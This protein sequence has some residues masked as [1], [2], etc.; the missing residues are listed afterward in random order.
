[1]RQMSESAAAGLSVLEGLIRRTSV[2]ISEMSPL[3]GRRAYAFQFTRNS[4]SHM[5]V[6]SD[7]FLSDLPA[8]REYQESTK[9]YVEGL[10]GRM[11]NAS[12]SDFYCVSGIPLNIEIE[13]PTEPVP[14]YTASSVQVRVQDLRTQD[15]MAI[16]AVRI[17]HQQ[18]F[19]SLQKDPFLKE[20]AVVNSIRAAADRNQLSYFRLNEHPR[21]LPWVDL[22]VDF[23]RAANEDEIEQ[24][25]L[26]KIYWLGFKRG[27]RRTLVWIADPWDAKYLGTPVGMLTQSAQILEAEKMISLLDT[28]QRFASAG[29]GL[30]VRSKSSRVSNSRSG[31]STVGQPDWNPRPLWD[32]FVCHASEDKE[33]F[34][35]PLAG[36]LREQNLRVW[37][38][39][40]ELKLGDSLRQS[41]DRGLRDSKFGIVVLSHAFFTKPWP[42][43]ELDGLTAREVDGKKVILP[44]WH[45]LTKEEVLKYSPMLAEK[46]AVSSSKGL[47]AVVQEIL[48]V[49]T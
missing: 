43:R 13:W 8:S 48:K 26:G 23:C 22:E 18:Q 35:K 36:A 5:I 10:E 2:S 33:E 25:L 9:A 19:F 37:Y 41:I 31:L 28:T 32:V 11:L 38:D 16:C 3:Q 1:M 45:N 4:Q 46:L 12:V 15:K 21:Q 6:L 30:L 42:Q 40:F 29:D 24:F 34:V 14:G 17:S 39:E 20:L 49:L 27:E 47:D 7:E 44:I